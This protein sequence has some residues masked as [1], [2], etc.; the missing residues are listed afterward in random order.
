MLKQQDNSKVVKII[1]NIN[2]KFRDWIIPSR[3]IENHTNLCVMSRGNWFVL[4]Y[5]KRCLLTEMPKRKQIRFP[6]LRVWQ[7]T[8]LYL[9]LYVICIVMELTS[10]NYLSYLFPWPFRKR[11]KG[12]LVQRAFEDY[13]RKNQKR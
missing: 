5:F 13:K 11:K 2:W 9:L 1:R 7:G 3:L 8:N 6:F 4:A 12:G 10:N